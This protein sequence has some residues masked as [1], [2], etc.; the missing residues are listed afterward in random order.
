M[1]YNLHSNKGIFNVNHDI[2]LA[3][4][5]IFTMSAPIVDKG[6]HF[7]LAWNYITHSIIVIYDSMHNFAKCTH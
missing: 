7:T 3:P 1:H 2:K 6:R 5:K 4:P